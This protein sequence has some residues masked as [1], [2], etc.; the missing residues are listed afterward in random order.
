MLLTDAVMAGDSHAFW[1]AL[2]ERSS[3]MQTLFA[4]LELHSSGR[5]AFDAAKA[6]QYDFAAVR[7]PGRGA[8]RVVR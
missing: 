5:E 7:T 3:L 6:V 1:V 8:L 4:R 2:A